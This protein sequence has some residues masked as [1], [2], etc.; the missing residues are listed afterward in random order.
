MLKYERAYRIQQKMKELDLDGFLITSKENRQYITGFTGSFGW[1]LITRSNVYLMTDSRYIQ[2]A[3]QQAQGCKL[4][5]FEQHSPVVT[6]RM[7]MEELDV[8]TIGI[9]ADR[10]TYDEFERIANNVRRKCVTPLVGFVDHERRIKDEEELKLIAKAEEI[11]DMAFTHILDYIKPGVT[12]KEIA[13]ELEYFMRRNGAEGLSFETI[14]ASG[15]RSS[16]PHGMPTDKAIEVGDFVTMD[17]G[18]LYQGYCSDMTRTIAVGKVDEQ[19]EKVY[20]L[21]LEAQSAALKQIKAGVVGKDIHNVA[22]QVF[23]D[24]GYGNFFGHGLGHSVGL[25]IHEK[26]GFSPSEHE[27][28]EENMVI[29][30]EPGLYLQNWGGVRIEDLVVV[31]K[32]GY[33]NLTHSPKQLIIL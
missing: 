2:Q 29:S 7:V 30:V 1:V 32:D 9:E 21:V 5:K 15:V 14:V 28:V 8:V 31:K 20:N 10:L 4:V 6:L 12:E 18:C 26:P 22:H 24:A 13:L 11:G 3:A 27:T 25:E 19:Q 33:E 16:M 23:K 17:Y